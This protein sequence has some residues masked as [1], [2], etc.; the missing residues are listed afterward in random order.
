MS[1]KCAWVVCSLLIATPAMGNPL[2]EEVEAEV[3]AAT[4]AAAHEAPYVFPSRPLIKAL[5]AGERINAPAT[6]DALVQ[7]LHLVY[8]DFESRSAG[9]SES[10]VVSLE[11]AEARRQ[12]ALWLVSAAHEQ[13]AALR[14]VASVMVKVLSLEP[15]VETRNQVLT[16]IASGRAASP[17]MEQI[18]IGL[19]SISRASMDAVRVSQL[20]RERA[21]LSL[22]NL[23]S[24]AES[25]GLCS[26]QIAYPRAS[27][28]I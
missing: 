4:K 7:G 21:S 16:A 17:L 3:R 14:A 23:L 22:R 13:P 15:H 24:V 10:E 27:F 28:G 5:F 25:H 20:E 18:A 2:A 6:T 12:F 9:Q 11:G 1:S 19:S 8:P 26:W